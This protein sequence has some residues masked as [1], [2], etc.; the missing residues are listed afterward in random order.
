MTLEH[1]TE[2]A[3]AIDELIA[4]SEDKQ[5]SQA[6]LASKAMEIQEALAM[7]GVD[8]PIDPSKLQTLEPIL[9][10]GVVHENVKLHEGEENIFE[11]CYKT[12]VR[13]VKI[14]NS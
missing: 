5:L 4:E 7:I 11:E 6:V 14:I 10:R 1:T 9:R 12:Y 8:I 2:D 3:Q 13:V